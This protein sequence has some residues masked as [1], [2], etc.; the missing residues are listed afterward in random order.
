MV[1]FDRHFILNVAELAAPRLECLAVVFSIDK[2]QRLLEHEN[3]LLETD[4]QALSLLLAHL[5]E[6][7]KIGC[8]VVKISAFKFHVQ[9]VCGL[10]NLTADALSPI[11]NIATLH[12]K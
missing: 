8:W 9:H 7:G 1:N 6:L 4:N 5:R 12:L 11:M 2:F 10:Q 3:F